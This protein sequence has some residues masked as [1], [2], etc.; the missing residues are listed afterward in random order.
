MIKGHDSAY[1]V[2]VAF[3]HQPSK[4]EAVQW[5]KYLT[6]IVACDSRLKGQ[7]CPK[8]MDR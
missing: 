4:E 5:M 1:V 2:Q 3:H 8:Q 6:K 7:E